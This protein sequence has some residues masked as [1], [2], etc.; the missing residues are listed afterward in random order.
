MKFIHCA[1]LHLASPLESRFSPE[2]ARK[3]R[4]ELFDTFARLADKAEAEGVCA[5][6]IAGDIFD[7]EKIALSAKKKFIKIVSAHPKT[8]FLCLSG[9]HDRSLSQELDLPENLKTF[10]DEW[11]KYTYG[12]VDVY[13]I[14][15]TNENCSALYASLL[16]D[17]K[18]TNIVMMHGQASESRSKYSKDT[19]VLPLLR[20]KHIDYLALGHIHS[21]SQNA[22][23]LR[24]VYAYSGC[25]EGR[26]YD[27]IGEK[28]Y[29]LLDVSN[30]G[31]ASA[32]VPFSRRTIHEYTM[33]ISGIEENYEIER[34]LDKHL[35][36][37]DEKDLVRVILNGQLGSRVQIFTQELEEKLNGRFFH[38]SVKDQTTLKIDESE[39]QNELS[40]KGEFVR[41]VL[42]SS[43]S[44]ED[45]ARVIRQGLRAL[46]AEEVEER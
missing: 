38:A 17:E 25:L 8:D 43:L 19:V 22:L 30:N 24:G 27:E 13:G 7:E 23:D 18:R 11:C 36:S 37:I 44:K 28:G 31:I 33:D 20:D 46:E 42:A 45:Q 5:V 21:Y 9:N 12:S 16:P 15:L 3:R 26:G 6:L 2:K 10:R 1:D 4:N 40:L 41:K 35:A 34:L 29:V 14:E 39:Y 32:F